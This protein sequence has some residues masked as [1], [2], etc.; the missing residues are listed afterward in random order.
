MNDSPYHNS[1]TL[2]TSSTGPAHKQGK[3]GLPA[4]TEINIL[5]AKIIKCDF[6]LLVL[7]LIVLVRGPGFNSPV[8]HTF[9]FGF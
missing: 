1:V 4:A 5:A 7:R 6:S 8:P 3:H 2:R 9:N